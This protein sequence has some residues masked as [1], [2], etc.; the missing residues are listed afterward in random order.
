V[1]DIAEFSSELF[2][3]FLPEES[4]VNPEVY[5]AELAYWLARKLSEAGIF[6]SYPES[7]D[8][9]WLLGYE[10]GSG[11]RFMI[12]CRN[13]DESASRWNLAIEAVARKL[14]GR[15]KPSYS[16]AGQAIDGIRAAL[17]EDPEIS[18]L[19]C[20]YSASSDE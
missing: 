3:P 11:A 17:T 13:V 19:S 18:E 9:G 8:W 1:L 12:L 5:G 7:E 4:Q 14:F 20:L 15:D 6:T 2:R 16:E 10:T